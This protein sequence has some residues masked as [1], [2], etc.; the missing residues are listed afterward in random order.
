MPTVQDILQIKGSRVHCVEPG[1]TVL[2][3]TQRMNAERIGAMVVTDRGR[4]AG[5][6]TERDV[7]RRI[8]AEQRDPA[9]VLVRDVMSTPVACCE[10]EMSIDDARGVMRDRRIRHL[11]VVTST[12]EL[13]G[14]ISIGDLNAY[15]V[16]GQQT[17]IHLLHEYLYGRT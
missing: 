3:A 9:T 16:D 7:L 8:V 15:E 17:T 12:G 11:P 5:M 10:P 14:L 4:V 13:L 2:A 1:T 6:F